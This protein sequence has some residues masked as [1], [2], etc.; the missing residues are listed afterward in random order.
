MVKETEDAMP[1]ETEDAMQKV[2]TT[3]EPPGWRLR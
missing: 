3:G 1:K 2:Y